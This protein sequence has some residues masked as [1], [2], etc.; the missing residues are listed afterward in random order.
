[1]FIKTRNSVTVI[2]INILIKIEFVWKV[3]NPLIR[4]KL[5]STQIDHIS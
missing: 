4:K 3:Q 1:M 2:I 5:S